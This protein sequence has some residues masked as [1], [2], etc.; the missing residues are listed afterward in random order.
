MQTG[1]TNDRLGGKG[2]TRVEGY[3]KAGR[4]KVRRIAPQCGRRLSRQH[5]RI[6]G[7]LGKMVS[8]RLGFERKR[9]EIK[10]CRSV[11]PTCDGVL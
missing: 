9:K 6:E 5:S 1:G 8:R 11:E 10:H 7:E 4:E 3:A 2:G